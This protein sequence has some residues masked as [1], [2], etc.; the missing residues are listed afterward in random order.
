VCNSRTTTGCS[1]LPCLNTPP[2]KTAIPPPVV[3]VFSHKNEKNVTVIFVAVVLIGFLPLAII[4]QEEG[5]S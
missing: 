4:L 1:L 2:S 3:F 5:L